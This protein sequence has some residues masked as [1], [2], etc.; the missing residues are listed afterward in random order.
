MDRFDIIV[1]GSG[2]GM[3][4][5]YNAVQND[6]GVALIEQGQVGGTCLNY[7]CIPSKMLI[8][9][10]DLIRTLQEQKADFHAVPTLYSLIRRL[11]A[12][13]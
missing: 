3:H 5:V 11:Q 9:P 12:W 7:G 10:A 8:Y 13:D 4:I 6:M 1:I 2:A